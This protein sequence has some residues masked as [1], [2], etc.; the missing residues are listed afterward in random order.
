M[1]GAGDSSISLQPGLSIDTIRR[2]SEESLKSELKKCTW[3][4]PS[5]FKLTIRYM[6]HVDAYKASQYPGAIMLT[7]KSVCYEDRDYDNIMRFILFCV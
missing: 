4:Y 5:R 7:P 2:K 6:K 3:A 1:H